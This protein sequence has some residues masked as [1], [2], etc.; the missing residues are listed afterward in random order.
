MKQRLKIHRKNFETVF[1]FK[2][3]AT[4]ESP[5]VPTPPPPTPPLPLPLPFPPLVFPP[6]SAGPITGGTLPPVTPSFPGDPL[7]EWRMVVRRTIKFSEIVIGVPGGQTSQGNSLYQPPDMDCIAA[8]D[9]AIGQWD[10]FYPQ[11]A[12]H[13]PRYYNGLSLANNPGVIIEEE[14]GMY[15]GPLNPTFGE[16]PFGWQGGPSSMWRWK[17][18]RLYSGEG[19]YDLALGDFVGQSSDKNSESYS[20][21]FFYTGESV[22]A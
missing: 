8:L 2:I 19:W 4:M 21:E 18:S 12:P 16:V 5:F 14:L 10:F 3:N 17:Q 11:Y 22:F 1:S 9:S 15:T 20:V 7:R 6:L 13:G